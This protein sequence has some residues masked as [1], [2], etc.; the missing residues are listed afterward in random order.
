[1]PASRALLLAALTASPALGDEAFE[2]LRQKA[3]P[4]DSLS[5]FAER[6]VG[7]C[8]DPLERA[9][10]EANVQEARKAA[11][12]RLFA[13]VIAEARDLIRVERRGAGYRFL[14]TP[15]IDAGGLGLTRGE[16]KLDGRG[17]P[18]IPYLVIDSR[19]GADEATVDAALRTGRVELEIIFRPEG[20]WKLK[21]RGEDGF[22]EGVKA[23]FVAVRLVDGRTGTEVA[24]KILEPG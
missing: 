17:R 15:F 24:V 1:M 9:A 7:A 21:R 5:G 20:V 11:R 10:C 4:L 8:R 19:P 22:Y 6:F 18:A 13:T 12:G 23:R 14:V 16:P 2:S 3:E